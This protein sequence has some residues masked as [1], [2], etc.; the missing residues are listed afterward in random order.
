MQRAIANLKLKRASIHEESLA[1]HEIPDK[2]TPV[3][4]T[5]SK[6]VSRIPKRAQPRK[7]SLTAPSLILPSNP[8]RLSTR[9]PFA[10]SAAGTIQLGSDY[11]ID[12]QCV[13]CGE[14]DG[15]FQTQSEMDEH[16]MQLCPMLM[17]CSS[18]KQVVEISGLHEH[19]LSECIFHDKFAKCSRCHQVKE[20]TVIEKHKTCS[21]LPENMAR[22]PLCNLTFLQTEEQWQIH[23]IGNY[24]CKASVRR[25]LALQRVDKRV[26]PSSVKGSTLAAR[27]KLIPNISQP[28]KSKQ[29]EPSKISRIPR[30]AKKFTHSI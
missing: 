4:G 29:P 2:T 10:P 6:T 7:S 30:P 19:M 23:L 3:T 28:V 9:T 12:N 24:G 14:E 8:S 22:C 5:P 26:T 13:F 15:A 21:V 11:A 20:K 17:P 27:S 1:N 16:F 18:C 25:Q